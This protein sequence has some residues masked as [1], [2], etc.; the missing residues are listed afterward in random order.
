M[1]SPFYCTILHIIFLIITCSLIKRAITMQC[2]VSHIIWLSFSLIMH[3]WLLFYFYLMIFIFFYYSWF[4]VFCQFSTVHQGDPVTHTYI[5][6]FLS[7]FFF[8]SP[9]FT[10]RPTEVYSFS[11][12]SLKKK[13]SF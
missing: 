10:H 13:I 8:L 4:T 6:F 2:K 7:F 11:N 12:Y 3:P 1:D 5:Y 9:Y